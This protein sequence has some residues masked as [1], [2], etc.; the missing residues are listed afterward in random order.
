MTYRRGRQWQKILSLLAVLVWMAVIYAFSA[1]NGT[2]SKALSDE[3]VDEIT[4]IIYEDEEWAPEIFQL[5]REQISRIVR[6]T[7]H[8]LEYALLSVLLFIAIRQWFV[9]EPLLAALP[10]WVVSV[11]YAITDEYHQTHV[12]GRGGRVFDV[13]IDGSG[14]LLALAIMLVVL[15]AR[16]LR[17]AK[18]SEAEAGEE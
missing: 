18:A 5:R 14:A 11:L 7:A 12:Y 2:T 3:I 13:M 1:Q 17:R 6:K 15:Y 16:K 10:A 9:V 4:E 8:A